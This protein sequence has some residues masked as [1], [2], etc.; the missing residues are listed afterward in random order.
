M[1]TIHGRRRFGD[2][3]KRERERA[4]LECFAFQQVD[5]LDRDISFKESIFE[6]KR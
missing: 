5:W 6:K 1:S 2:K 4:M 3:R